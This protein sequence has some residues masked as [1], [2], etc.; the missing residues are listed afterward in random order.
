MASMRRQFAYIQPVILSILRGQY[1]A[2][3]LH[4]DFFLGE[5]SR[6]EVKDT[7]HVYGNFGEDF[8]DA[9]GEHLRKWLLGADFAEVKAVNKDDLD[10]KDIPTPQ[11]LPSPTPTPG[12]HPRKSTPS[13]GGVSNS[14]LTVGGTPLASSGAPLATLVAD[15]LSEISPGANSPPSDTEA[16]CPPPSS[17]PAISEPPIDD[18]LASYEDDAMID[19]QFDQNLQLLETPSILH[20]DTHNIASTHSVEEHT[21]VPIDQNDHSAAPSYVRSPSSSRR[22]LTLLI[23]VG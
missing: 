17:S 16:P 14:V 15:E 1:T 11:D 7:Q 3:K 4:R 19:H 10:T 2:S 20:L 8:V 13:I 9:L 12:V 18:P 5:K 22:Y 23:F 21:P 6:Q